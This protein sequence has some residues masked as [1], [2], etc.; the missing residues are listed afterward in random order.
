MKKKSIMIISI[1]VALIL[2]FPIPFRLKDGGSIEFRALLYTI[3]KYHKLALIEDADNGYIEGIGIE[4]LGMEIYNSTENK[5][6]KQ[7]ETNKTSSNG[8][9]IISFENINNIHLLDNFLDNIE[10]YNENKVDSSVEIVTYTIEGDAIFTTLQYFEQ[11]NEIKVIRDNTKDRFASAED[12]KVV[13]KVYSCSKYNLVK[14]INNELICV[15]LEADGEEELEDIIIFSYDKDLE[16]NKDTTRTRVNDVTLI[17]EETETTQL[18]KYNGV[19]YGKFY[20]MIDYMGNPNGPIGRINK[21]IGEEYL[22]NLD[23]ETNSEELLNA[24]VD[25]ANEESMVLIYDNEAVLY[26]AI[27]EIKY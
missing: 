7:N 18:V 21:L 12:R 1:V 9:V 17:T 3:T 16:K 6:S 5:D 8:Q 10:K 23:G 25:Y 2:L 24:L 13:E 26:F 27:K 11:T 15:M 20:G 14:K 22:P 4:I 19:L